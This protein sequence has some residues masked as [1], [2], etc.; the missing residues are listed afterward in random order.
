M[1][2]MIKFQ[3]LIFRLISNNRQ[4]EIGLIDPLLI[5]LNWLF[6]NVILLGAV[7]DARWQLYVPKQHLPLPIR[8]KNK[9][10]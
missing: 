2:L 4:K 5:F 9:S 3:L 10:L 1:L 7:G 8:L 6:V